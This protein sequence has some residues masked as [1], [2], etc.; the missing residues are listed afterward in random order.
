M[1]VR[2]DVAPPMLAWALERS[3]L[4]SDSLTKRFPRLRDWESGRTKPT[5]R[6]LEA[7][8]QATYTP[9]GYFFLPEPPEEGLPVPDYRTV[10]DAELTRPSANLLDTVYLSEQ[11]QD[12]YRNYQRQHGGDRLSFVGSVSPQSPARD[13]AA[14]MTTALGFNLDTRRRFQT[15]TAALTG[16][17]EAA[18][19]I[20]I[21]VV[22]SGIVASNTRRRLDPDEFRGF[23]LN[24]DLAPLIFVNGADTKAAQIFTLAHELAHVWAGQSGV[25]KPDLGQVDDRSATE[26][27]CNSVAA[28]FLVPLESMPKALQGPT[29]TQDL[30]RLARQYKVSTLVVLR[31]LVDRGLLTWEQF[32]PAFDDELARVT[33][34]AAQRS[35]GGDFYRTQPYRVSR[36]FARAIIS[37]A[38]EGD[39][40]YRDA[41]RL[42]G[43]RRHETFQ[44]LGEAVGVA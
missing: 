23:A 19:S 22:V 21:L 4:D 2:I 32:R 30:E 15:W 17:I 38:L 40:L 14:Q 37:D 39:T 9:F 44:N 27:W 31:R 8:A 36:R 25:D 12:W 11:R 28:E 10:R 18:E 13:V 20:G 42:L 1:S 16:L 43:V 3:G 29:L 35:P 5:V 34:L 24:D 7:F 41:Y 6:Q 26:R 33:D